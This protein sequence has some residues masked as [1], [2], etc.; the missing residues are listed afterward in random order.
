MARLAG[1]RVTHG[2]CFTKWGFIKVNIHM[3]PQSFSFFV[4]GCGR[5][6]SSGGGWLVAV[7]FDGFT[8]FANQ[9][10]AKEKGFP[11]ARVR[12]IWSFLVCG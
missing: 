4:S 8:C 9:Q 7:R 2:E 3:V 6:R 12:P 10:R 11:A 5:E 1:F